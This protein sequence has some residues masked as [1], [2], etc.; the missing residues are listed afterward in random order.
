MVAI[1]KVREFVGTESGQIR[2]KRQTKR[3]RK[4]KIKKP[5]DLLQAP[6]IHKYW[7]LRCH[8]TAIDTPA[9]IRES[10]KS[11]TSIFLLHNLD[12]PFSSMRIFLS[13]Q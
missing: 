4:N 12:H 3:G 9:I 1:A 5:L 8:M 7:V 6:T 11:Y 13:M 10:H 2:Y